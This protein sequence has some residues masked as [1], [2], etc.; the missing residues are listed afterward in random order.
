MRLM[1]AFR[2]SVSSIS[3]NVGDGAVR[4]RNYSALIGRI[5]AVWIAKKSE[6]VKNQRDKNKR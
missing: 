5:G 2:T 4:R 3:S 1:R 6:G